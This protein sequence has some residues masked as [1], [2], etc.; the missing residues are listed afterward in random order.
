MTHELATA[1][2]RDDDLVRQLPTQLLCGLERQR[3]GALR[4]ERADVDVA[5]SPRRRFDELAAQPVHVVVVAAHGHQVR[6]EDADA[7]DLRRLEVDRDEDET[8]E[9]GTS[10]VRRDCIRQVARRGARDRLETMRTR[11]ADR[12]RD[13]A[14]LERVGRVHAVV[15]QVE[16]AQAELRAQPVRLD[17]GCE[18]FAQGD[19]RHRILDWEQVPIPPHRRRPL[20]D[21]LTAHNLLQRRPHPAGRSTSRIR[22][23]PAARTRRRTRGSAGL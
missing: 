17:Q 23:S 19:D 18:T 6:I 12:H 8:L 3:F 10:R 20:L 16:V 4:V 22:A 13:D 9:S 5:E 11:P 14:V 7:R 15:F 21:A 1:R 2:D